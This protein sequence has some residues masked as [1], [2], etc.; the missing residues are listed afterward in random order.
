MT[1]HRPSAI[2]R[3]SNWQD[4][5]RNGFKAGDIGSCWK[6]NKS[7]SISGYGVMLVNGVQTYVHRIAYE[8]ANGPVPKGTHVLHSCDMPP[9]V[10]PAH[11]FLGTQRDNNSDKISKKRQAMGNKFPQAKLTPE[12]VR[13]I[14]S[15]RK[16]GRSNTDLCKEIGV[17]RMC[18]SRAA[19]SIDWRHVH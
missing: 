4:R 14:R 10:N 6:W 11:L 15:E 1:N 17:S 3:W 12:I 9:C 13:Y 5:F 19:R 18:V 8:L 2:K 7:C 16:K